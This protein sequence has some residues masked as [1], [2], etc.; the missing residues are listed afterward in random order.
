MA[1]PQFV[2][3]SGFQPNVDWVAY[4][5]WAA[6]WDGISRVAIKATEGVG[7]TDPSFYA[8]REGALNAG[9][10]VLILYHYARPDLGNSPEA[11][12]DSFLRIV[13][14]LRER[15]IAILDIECDTD[16][17]LTTWCYKWLERVKSVSGRVTGLYSYWGYIIEHLQYSELAAYPLW[18]ANWAYNPD[19]RPESPAP[20]GSYQWL[21]WTDRGVVPGISGAVDV[22]I[23]IGGT[24]LNG[25]VYSPE[26]GDFAHWFTANDGNHWTCKQTGAIIRYANLD[27]YRKLSMDGNSLPM[28]G[29]PLESEQEHTDA[30]GYKWSD[31][32]FERATMRYDPE[33]RK[34]SQPGAGGSYLA[35]VNPPKTIIVE[36]LPDAILADIQA[37]KA[38]SDKLAKDAQI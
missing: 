17:K 14:S 16:V 13:G 21:Q 4:R 15:D 9:V 36:K 33:H 29:L 1:S 35:H 30:D 32:Q 5:K 25:T 28:P 19:A 22:N 8:H 7:F 12:A 26:K 11:E 37:L 34:D 18:Y 2:D 23:A 20:W 24:T 27:F 3:I 10:D 38:A 31:Q 6:Q